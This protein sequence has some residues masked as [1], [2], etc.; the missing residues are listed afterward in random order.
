ILRVSRGRNALERVRSPDDA[1]GD[2]MC[3]EQPSHEDARSAT[4]YAGLD[5]I[6]RNAIGHHRFDTVLDVVEAC[7]ADHGVRELEEV[8][9]VRRAR[10]LRHAD[11]AAARFA[12][13]E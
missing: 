13:A 7:A 2:A 11:T 6:T 5:E 3:R 9:H 4:P 10:G 8:A 1:I 12:G